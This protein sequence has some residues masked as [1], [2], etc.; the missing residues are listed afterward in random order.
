MV[1]TNNTKT[2]RGQK[3]KNKA[4]NSWAFDIFALKSSPFSMWGLRAK[5]FGM[6]LLVFSLVLSTSVFAQQANVVN[7]ITDFVPFVNGG[8]PS[9]TVTQTSTKFDNSANVI[10]AT[11]TNAATSNDDQATIRVLDAVNTY[12][13][14]NTVGFRASFGNGSIIIKLYNDGVL[15]QTSATIGQAGDADYSITATSDYDA[16]ELV[17][18]RACFFGCSTIDVKY[19]I[20]RHYE[21]GT[22][23][24][25][26]TNAPLSTTTYPLTITEDAPVANFRNA[27]S[28]S[29]TD[30]ATLNPASFNPAGIKISD[31]KT[32]YT[33]GTFVGFDV[34]KASFGTN[35]YSN[36]TIRTYLNGSGTNNG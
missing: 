26:S 34:S 4:T 18:T 23:L 15:V 10:D 5:S 25:C 14:G 35:D 9:F 7:P 24:I 19:A 30:F 33:A 31:Q 32:D 20:N 29:T 12:S 1:I 28:A 16:V 22:A 27:I 2:I 11:L 6:L 21:A 17:Y 13:S 8:T 3:G 36:I